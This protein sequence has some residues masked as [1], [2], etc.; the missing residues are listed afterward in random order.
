MQRH[1]EKIVYESDRTKPCSEKPD[2]H[3][4]ILGIMN[5]QRNILRLDITE[6]EKEL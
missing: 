4:F 1:L 6:Q 3:S 2:K 5:S